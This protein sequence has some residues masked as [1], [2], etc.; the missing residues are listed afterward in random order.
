MTYQLNYA[1]GRPQMYDKISRQ[2]KGIRIVKALENH[3]GSLQKLKILDVGASTG[4]IDNEL[5]KYFGKVVGVDIDK[6]AIKFASWKFKRINLRFEVGDAM[7]LKYKNK[8]FDVIICT[9]VYEHVPDTNKLFTEIYRVLKPEGIVYLAAV[10]A[11][12]PWEPHYDLPFLS[13][14]PKSLGNL[15]VRLTGK[16]KHYYETPRS[17]GQLRKMI[18]GAGFKIYD[19][20]VKIINDP[21]KYGY[22]SSWELLRPVGFLAKYLSPTFFWILEK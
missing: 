1:A 7:K 21:V 6:Q 12:W 13:W 17:Y 10:N 20:T 15:Y 2:Q 19:Y 4:I 8:S 3:L 11:L 16:A 5:A 22:P 18:Y 9:H 14:L